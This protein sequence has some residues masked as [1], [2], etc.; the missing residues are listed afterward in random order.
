MQYM[1]AMH[2][3]L[4]SVASGDVSSDETGIKAACIA[5]QAAYAW[6]WLSLAEP[7]R[8]FQSRC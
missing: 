4:L 6:D 5:V 3:K 7:C 1:T 8:S 2:Y